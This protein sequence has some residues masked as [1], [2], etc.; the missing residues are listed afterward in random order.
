MN[1]D[2][3]FRLSRLVGVTPVP[4]RCAAC[5]AGTARFNSFMQFSSVCGTHEC[6]S[7]GFLQLCIVWDTGAFIC[8]THDIS[9]YM[10]TESHDGGK[11]SSTQTLETIKLFTQCT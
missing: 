9:F 1:S 3:P 4:L 10:N 2:D 7:S 8:S 5:V 6:S 11:Q